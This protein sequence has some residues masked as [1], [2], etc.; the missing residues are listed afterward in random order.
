MASIPIGSTVTVSGT[1]ITS[2]KMNNS[3]PNKQTGGAEYWWDEK[4]EPLDFL[5]DQLKQLE[6]R[7]AAQKG[8][9]E[10]VKAEFQEN[11]TVA[12]KYEDALRKK[13]QEYR[14]AIDKIEG[15]K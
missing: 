4:Q 13:L 1:A 10:H 12:H 2:A 5:K 14:H 3:M 6:Q 11:I 7:I 9:I 15:S 8:Y